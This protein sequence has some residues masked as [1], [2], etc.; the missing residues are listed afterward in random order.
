MLSGFEPVFVTVKVCVAD[1][2]VPTLP[3][4]PLA[5]DTAIVVAV[6]GS[7]ALALV[8]PLQPA[9]AMLISSAAVNAM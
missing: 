5:P 7:V 4:E 8:N 9:C 3:N 2:P 1:A 6:A